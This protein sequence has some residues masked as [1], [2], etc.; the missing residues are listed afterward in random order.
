MSRLSYYVQKSLESYVLSSQIKISYKGGLW[1]YNLMSSRKLARRSNNSCDC[2]GLDTKMY[3]IKK[4]N[5]DPVEG[6]S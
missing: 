4:E 2:A 6:K 5:M 3:I 1:K